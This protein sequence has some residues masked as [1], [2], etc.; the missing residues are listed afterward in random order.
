MTDHNTVSA[1]DIG[2]QAT[3]RPTNLNLATFVDDA[4]EAIRAH[5]GDSRVICALSGGVDSSV[6]ATLMHRAIGDKLTCVFVN[7]G[8]LRQG[9]ADEVIRVF[10]DQFK[11]D[12]VYVDAEDRYLNLLAGVTDPEQKRHIIGGEFWKVFFE[13]AAKIDGVKFLAQGTIYPDIVESG[14]E[15][16]SKVKSHH[17]LVPFPDG[18]HFDLIEPVKFLFK[19]EVRAIGSELGLPDSI[20]HRQPFPGPGLGVRVV[21]DLTK[22]KLDMLRGA[23]A[24]VREEI[25]AW[26]TDRTVWQFF[27]VLLDIQST[28]VK[29]GARTYARPV[30]I[31]AINSTNAMTAGVAELPYELL[32]KMANRIIAEVDGINRVAYDITQKPPGTIEWE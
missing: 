28:G 20:V 6:V 9:E 31:R 10:K 23:D 11:I 27:A 26:D 30:V 15:T 17:N 22:E 1:L 29:N 24:I 16:D 14:T 8:L 7:H 13:E 5:V 32:T 25:A 21:G 2:G 3:T 18:V 19:D 12:L 4:V